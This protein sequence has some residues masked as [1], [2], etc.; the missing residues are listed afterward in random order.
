MTAASSAETICTRSLQPSQKDP[1]RWRLEPTR[2]TRRV[3]ILISILLFIEY[4]D[5]V[6]LEKNVALE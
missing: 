4:C 1:V 3:S 5:T 2:H 6:A